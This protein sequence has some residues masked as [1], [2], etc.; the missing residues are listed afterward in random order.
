MN[1]TTQKRPFIAKGRLSIRVVV[2]VG[3]VALH[4]GEFVFKAGEVG[5][6]GKLG[7]TLRA[8]HGWMM[9]MGGMR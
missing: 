9:W 4:A 8:R 3:D 1:V 5:E 6:G 7:G 2:V